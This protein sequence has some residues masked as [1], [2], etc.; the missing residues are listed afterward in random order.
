MEERFLSFDGYFDIFDIVIRED[1]A[2]CGNSCSQVSYFVELEVNKGFLRFNPAADTS[3]V[4]IIQNRVKPDNEG[5]ILSF[6]GLL[7]DA[8]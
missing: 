5:F 2:A 4:T 3:K 1:T 8:N 6:R 7:A